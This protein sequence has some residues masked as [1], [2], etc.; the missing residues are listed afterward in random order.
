[1]ANYIVNVDIE[2]SAVD[3]EDAKEM[4]NEILQDVPFILK[5]VSEVV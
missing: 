2:V 4:L 3:I 5:D 1:M